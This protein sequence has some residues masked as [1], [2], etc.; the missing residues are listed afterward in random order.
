[1][2]VFDE[3]LGLTF[4]ARQRIRVRP[5]RA[6]EQG[7]PPHRAGRRGGTGT[8]R[9]CPAGPEC[10]SD[11]VARTVIIDSLNGYQAAMAEEKQL[12]LHMHELLQYL[13]N[14]IRN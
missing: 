7:P 4:R 11:R 10:V 9:V 13:N 8:G 6:G 14:T 2:F 3:E 5:R 12:I 1:M